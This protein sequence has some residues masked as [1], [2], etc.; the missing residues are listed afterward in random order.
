VTAPRPVPTSTAEIPPDVPV[1]PDAV[2]VFLSGSLV[3][4]W[5]HANSDVDLYVVAGA[6]V[7]AGTYRLPLRLVEGTI[8]QLT[9][10]GPD[11]RRWDVEYWT[12]GLVDDLLA[13][14]AVQTESLV[15]GDRL[16][17]ADIDCFY[18]MSI[19]RP[20]LGTDW[21]SRTQHRIAASALGRILATR[22]FFET[23]GFV[24]DA[25]G[26]L[27]S[28]DGPSAVLAAQAAL[29]HA[30]DGYL[31]ARGSLAP[32]PK[33]RYRKLA[34]L[35]DPLLTAAEYWHLTTMADLD[36][37][38]PAGWVESVARTCEKLVMEVDFA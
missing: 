7:A 21:L 20:L 12:A 3:A 10:Y 30:V 17:Y 27:V 16:G 25:L 35:P 36:R 34:E 1:P 18:R 32:S 24:D 13:A 15:A 23:D 9:T 11:G 4:G 28:G 37:R 2:C 29:G 26:M 14:V 8:T 31:Y 33:W 5:A 6:A 22:E 19:G 38:D